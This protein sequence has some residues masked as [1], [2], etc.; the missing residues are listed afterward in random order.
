[1]RWKVLLPLLLISLL[2]AAAIVAFPY[3]N[4]VKTADETPIVAKK[5]KLPPKADPLRI[6]APTNGIACLAFS[7][8]GKFLAAGGLDRSIR[9]WDSQTG[10]LL[11]TLGGH[12]WGISSLAFSPD[13]KTMVS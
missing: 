4:Q 8:D 9:M 13:G 2:A 7:P 11:R 5:P 12:T 1:M 3:W 10:K 6:E